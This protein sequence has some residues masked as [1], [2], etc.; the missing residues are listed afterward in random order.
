WDVGH[1]T[2]GWIYNNRK[3]YDVQSYNSD[4]SVAW[5][6]HERITGNPEVDAEHYSEWQNGRRD[7]LLSLHGDFLFNDAIGFTF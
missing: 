6:L 1:L 2:L 7:S 4:G 5:D 3:D